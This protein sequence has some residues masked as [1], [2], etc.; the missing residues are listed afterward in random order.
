MSGVKDM[1]TPAGR[2]TCDLAGCKSTFIAEKRKEKHMKE[3]HDQLLPGTSK[4]TATNDHAGSCLDNLATS[5]V[6]SINVTSQ[7]VPDDM[8]DKDDQELYDELDRIENELKE[9]D[10]EIT[11]K[12]MNTVT[13]L[14]VVIKKRTEI[15]IEFKAYHDNE[16]S[17][18]SEVEENL[19]ED[20]EKKEKEIKAIRERSLAIMK[21]SKKKRNA[22]KD[23][24]K[25]AVNHEKEI[26]NLHVKKGKT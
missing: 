3:K 5:Q 6:N 13:R 16:M 25:Q 2:F 7:D 18:R 17:K 1:T 14:R 15:Q 10:G 9:D 26:T 19:K 20:Y 12:M 4:Q 23:H 8:P 24:E 21:E 22:C 11:E